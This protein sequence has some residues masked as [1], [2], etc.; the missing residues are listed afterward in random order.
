MGVGLACI[1]YPPAVSSCIYGRCF[2]TTAIGVAWVY[3][4]TIFIISTTADILPIL[5]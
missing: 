3:T 4:L 1:S 2:E 5:V